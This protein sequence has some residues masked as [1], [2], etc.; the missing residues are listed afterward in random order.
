VS[1]TE[2]E[3]RYELIDPILRAKGYS[4]GETLS[5]SS[6][7]RRRGS[8]PERSASFPFSQALLQHPLGTH[9]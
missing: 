8:R 6:T 9:I 3:T 7:V 5:V 2:A 1:K 4:H